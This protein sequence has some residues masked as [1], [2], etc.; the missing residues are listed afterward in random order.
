MAQSLAKIYVHLVF[1]TKK[2]EPLIRDVV[3]PELHNYIGGILRDLDCP[4]VEINS[5]P[6]HAHV[7]SFLLS[8][9]DARSERCHWTAQ[10]RL[11]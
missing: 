5:E 10:P 8:H 1:S 2:R 4:A 7:L 6:D 11:L 9:A 3:R